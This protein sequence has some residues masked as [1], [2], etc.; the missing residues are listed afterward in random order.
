MPS[1]RPTPKV[2][3]ASTASQIE[4]AGTGPLNDGF[5]TWSVARPSAVVSSTEDTANTSEPA[6]DTRNGLGCMRT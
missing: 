6:T 5:S 1:A 2:M 3:S 4:L